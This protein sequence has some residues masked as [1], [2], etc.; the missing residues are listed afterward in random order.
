[1]I[2]D[3]FYEQIKFLSKIAKSRKDLI[4]IFKRHPNEIPENDKIYLNE[5]QNN[6]NIFFIKDELNNHDLLKL[7][8]QFGITNHFSASIP[9]ASLC[10]LI[11][12]FR[13]IS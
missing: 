4:W 11:V 3:D 7:N 12:A 6:E 2:F 5:F 1:M 8:I 9:S 10:F 13:H